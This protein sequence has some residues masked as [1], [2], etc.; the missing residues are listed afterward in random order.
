MGASLLNKQ[1]TINNGQKKP[2]LTIKTHNVYMHTTSKTIKIGS[3]SC[4]GFENLSKSEQ[5]RHPTSIPIEEVKH[6]ACVCFFCS[7]LS[8]TG[9]RVL[10]YNLTTAGTLRNPLIVIPNHG[11]IPQTET[12]D[13]NIVGFQSVQVNLN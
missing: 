8:Y 12:R 11:A 5:Y 2:K 10:I 4:F 7:P 1:T 9:S 6:Y 13:L 3:P